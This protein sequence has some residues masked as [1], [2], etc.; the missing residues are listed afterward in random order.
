VI[1]ARGILYLVDSSLTLQKNILDA[2][3]ELSCGELTCAR[4]MA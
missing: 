2:V 3:P 4:Q 1:H